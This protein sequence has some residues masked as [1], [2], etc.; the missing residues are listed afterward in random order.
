MV[1]MRKWGN[2]RTMRGVGE[3]EETCENRRDKGEQ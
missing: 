2:M 1:N 3:H